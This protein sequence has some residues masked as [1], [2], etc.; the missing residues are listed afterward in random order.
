LSLG[1][2]IYLI[3]KDHVIAPWLSR[4]AER[5]FRLLFWPRGKDPA[6]WKG[7]REPGWN[8]KVWNVEDYQEGMNVGVLLGSELEP[9]KFLADVDFDWTEGLPL[10]KS[11]L[12]ATGFGFGR[13]SRSTS[14]AFYTTSAPVISK[15]YDDIDGKG[16]VEI[17][18]TKV[19]G[20]LGLQTMLPPSVHPNGE[21][22]E[23]KLDEEIYHADTLP[24]RVVLYAIACMLLQHLGHRG[25]LHDTRLA[26]AGFLLG[27]GLSEDDV[28][29]I[30]TAVALVSGN[31]VNDVK[32]TLQTTLSQLKAGHRVQGAGALIKAIGDDGKKVV[33][34]I[35]EWLGASDFVADGHD[36]IIRDNQENIHRALTKLDISLAF[37]AFAQTPTI[38]YNGFAGRLEDHMEDQVWLDIDTKFHFRPSREFFHTVVLNQTRQQTFHPVKEYLSG[39]V[40]DGVERLDAWLIKYAGAAESEY[41]RSV[42][43]MVL[44][45]AVR[46]VRQ[47]GCKFDE[48]MVLES[49]QGLQKSSALRVLCKNEQ[50]FSDD[51]PLNVDSK[52]IIERTAGKWII[53]AADLSGMRQSQVEHL[54]AMLSRQVD[55]ARLSYGR[56]L[57]EV[58]RQWI[59]IGT[60]NAH[61]YLKDSTGNRRFWPMRI[62]PFNLEG[63]RGVR[64]QLWA[65]ASSREEGGE[66]I[67]LSPKLYAFAEM[68]QE[69]RREEDPWEELIGNYF[70]E[71]GD[72]QRATWAELWE[73]VHVSIDRRNVADQKRI[74]DV[75]RLLGF[76]RKMVR[77][78]EGGKGAK[79]WSKD[80]SQTNL[81]DEKDDLD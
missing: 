6:T 67:R 7:P 79:G 36:K 72:R 73:I 70:L 1:S 45:A 57:S 25:L 19:D 64:D 34:R 37:D 47:P 61:V 12:P 65:E 16:F 39:L 24:H 32:T 38:K 43:A 76:K 4:Y 55:C 21:T 54:K 33:S 60:T 42:S 13:P 26:V 52:V 11:L 20:T 66:S 62:Q 2:E 29:T 51:L 48:M 31:D 10:A 69:R 71:N 28:L 41:A 68:Q 77:P 40:W 27:E 18:G 49:S 59:P 53:E 80:E 63:L 74:A 75:M 17:R 81:L 30:G 22:L 35:K 50:W 14:H 3:N 9:G 23:L 5:G 8:T 78:R 56:L 44:I 58:P 46:R 15:A